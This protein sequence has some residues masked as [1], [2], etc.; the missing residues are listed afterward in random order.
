MK[1]RRTRHSNKIIIF[2]FTQIIA[3]LLFIKCVLSYK[4]KSSFLAV[5]YFEIQL[6]IKTEN[7]TG[8]R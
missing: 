1:R 5:K 4:R 2:K 3:V 8:V 7:F 6:R